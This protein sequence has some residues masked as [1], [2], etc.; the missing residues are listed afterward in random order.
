MHKRCF[1]A[2][3]LRTCVLL[4][5]FIGVSVGPAWAQAS[6]GFYLSSERGA[7]FASGM[8]LIGDS[9][10]RESACDEFLNPWYLLGG[11]RCTTAARGEGD[12]WKSVFDK[13]KGIAAGGALVAGSKSFLTHQPSYPLAR[14]ADPS[15]PKLLVDARTSVTVAALSECSSDLHT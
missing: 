6:S 12:T 13:A 11:E 9:D 4:V 5:A 15:L 3:I 7:S 14:A 8:D 10:D 1:R 2:L